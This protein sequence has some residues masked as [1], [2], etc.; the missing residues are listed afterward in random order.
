MTHLFSSFDPKT[1]FFQL[2]WL[3]SAF[4]LLV[5]PSLFWLGNSQWNSL[6]KNTLKL[7]STEFQ[8]VLGSLRSPRNAGVFLGLFLFIFSNNAL[9]LLPYV[10]TS[11]RHLVF[12]LTLALPLWLGHNLYS[13]YLQPKFCLAHLIPRGTPAPLLVFMFCIEILSR[14]IRPLTLSVRLIANMIAGHLLFSLLRT[15]LFLNCFSITVYIA[16]AV[17]FT[18]I[19]LEL[20]VSFIQAYVFSLLSC[21]YVKDHLTLTLENH[22]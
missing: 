17:L 19:L 5:L 12:T 22:M 9:G 20:S 1:I 13:W 7:I 16:L 14:V 3:A 4:G 15:G 2:N 11:S 10:F 8:A 21:L 18:L 6:V